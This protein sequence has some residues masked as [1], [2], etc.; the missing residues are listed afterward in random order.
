MSGIFIELSVSAAFLMF[1]LRP[2]CHSRPR[3]LS[4]NGPD[5]HKCELG[6]AAII[7]LQS[8]HSRHQAAIVFVPGSKVTPRA[9]P[10]SHAPWVWQCVTCPDVCDTD[11]PD[12]GPMLV[13]ML[14]VCRQRGQTRGGPGW[15]MWRVSAYCM[16]SH[17]VWVV[18]TGD[19]WGLV[20]VIG[21]GVTPGCE[22]KCPVLGDTEA[23]PGGQECHNVGL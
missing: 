17:R 12:T 8:A 10:P 4:L 23:G 5:C 9:C 15:D 7:W 3:P 11:V 16:A 1:S 20:A 18:T 6:A 13:M 14:T 2:L 22:T 21:P 19:H